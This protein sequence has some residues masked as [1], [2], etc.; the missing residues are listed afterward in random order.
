LRPAIPAIPAESMGDPPIQGNSVDVDVAVVGYGPVGAALAVL[1]GQLG[2]SVV[3]LER[4]LEPY[5]RPRAVHFDQQ[6]GRIL[7]A[8]GLGG[9]LEAI[10]EPAEIYE[11]RNARGQTLLRLGRAGVGSCGWPHSS[12]FHQPALEALLDQR[13]RA[14]PGIDVRRGAEVTAV[15][16]DRERVT[17]TSTRDGRTETVR[18]RYAVGCDGS[19]SIVRDLMASPVHDLGFFYDWL[20]VDVVLHEPRVFEPINVQI[21]DPARPVTQVSG[22]PGRRRWEFMRLPDEP[23]EALNDEATAW[24]LLEPFD[25]HPANATLERH[26]VYTFQ[27][28]SVSRWRAGRVLLAGDAAHQMPPFAGQGLCTG[29]R[30]AD[31][32]A[33]KL[34]LVLRGLAGDALL[35]SYQLERAPQV[36]KVIEFSVELGKVICVPDVAEAAARDEAMLAAAAQQETT[37]VPELPGIEE[38]LRAAGT[39][40]AGDTYLQGRV[41]RDGRAQRFDDAV[42]VGWRL[43][44]EPSAGLVA[45]LALDD[46]LAAWFAE[47][48]G[49]AVT[50][51]ASG[52]LEDLD[53][54]YGAWF[55]H[56][57]V[58]AALQRPDFHLYGT[59]R[60]GSGAVELLRA[61][62]RDLGG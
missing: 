9:Q 32:L 45:N 2:R 39:A 8:C 38:G 26:T 18:S 52:D 42:G 23:I 47:L 10:T 48:G 31:N 54:T 1:L 19:N 41:G 30:D 21:C 57:G 28:R 44:G 11:W 46:E 62:R 22:G 49:R 53:G 14:L 12:M 7:Q 35:D 16:Q 20:I 50:V 60:D 61:L 15:D 24:R 34:D 3:V 40:R 43:V 58:T 55:T 51:G 29:L 56:N 33:W 6:V 13:A 36:A 5:P 25:V 17:I 27:A 59:S 4:W 37:P